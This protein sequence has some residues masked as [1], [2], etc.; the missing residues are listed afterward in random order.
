MSKNY[1]EIFN[2]IEKS[3]KEFK[4]GNKQILEQMLINSKAITYSEHVDDWY[5]NK[6]KLIIFYSGFDRNS[7]VDKIEIINKHLPDIDSVAKFGDKEVELILGDKSMIQNSDK[8]NSVI[9]NATIFLEIKNEYGSFHQYLLSLMPEKD[10]KKVYNS[11]QGK[12]QNLGLI[13]TFIFM[14]EIELEI[15]QKNIILN[16]ILE[17]TGLIPLQSDH[18]KLLDEINKFVK[19]TSLPLRYIEQTL[20]LFG[21]NSGKG[22]CSGEPKCKFCELNPNCDFFNKKGNFL[23]DHDLDLELVN[24]YC[25]VEPSGEIVYCKLD[26]KEIEE[27]KKQYRKDSVMYID[28]LN[29]PG[30]MSNVLGYLTGM[31]GISYRNYNSELTSY[32]ELPTEDGFYLLVANLSKY[33]IAFDFYPHDK[34]P[35]DS[36]QFSTDYVRFNF[37]DFITPYGETFDHDV[38]YRYKYKSV[39]IEESID[40]EMVDRGIDSF[41]YIFQVKNKECQLIFQFDNWGSKSKIIW[42][43]FLD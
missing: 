16:R 24:Y 38:H 22:I 1:K 8:I 23:G 10:L 20:L 29:C 19:E 11:L 3:L 43:D 9:R 28:W 15:I 35:F 39:E 34:K 40:A 41:Y 6:L 33:S 31:F 42:G 30:N 36:S 21:E 37:G 25:K 12:L 2:K 13:S 5:F 4:E 7:I 18:W 27:F 32:H 14:N 17:R 26:E